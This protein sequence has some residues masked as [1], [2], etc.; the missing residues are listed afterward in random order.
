MC[1]WEI[2]TGNILPNPKHQILISKHHPIAKLRTNDIH[3]NYLWKGIYPLCP[4]AK[5]LHPSK[6][7]FNQK[8]IIQLLLL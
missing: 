3:L 1:W 7:R 6:Q 5:L 8:N 4:M 2:K